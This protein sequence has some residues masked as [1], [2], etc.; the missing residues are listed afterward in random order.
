MILSKCNSKPISYTRQS[1]ISAQLLH[2]SFEKESKPLATPHKDAIL[3]YLI[4]SLERIEGK[5]NF[6]KA[7]QQAKEAH[8]SF[9]TQLPKAYYY[10]KFCEREPS[11]TYGKK[12]GLY[13]PR[14]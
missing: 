11:E 9:T 13:F 4:L 2:K 1:P 8:A 12:P 14:Q 3:P 10:R 5:L 6:Q 7:I